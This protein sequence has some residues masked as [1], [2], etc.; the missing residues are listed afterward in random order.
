M[1]SWHI[2]AK[3]LELR[4]TWKISR[5][6]S[7]TK[8][9]L[10]VRVTDQ[11]HLGRGEAAPNVR[12][13]ETPELLLTQFQNLLANGLEYVSSLPELQT[14]LEQRSIA[15]ALRFAVESA[16]VHFTCMVQQV[17][18]SQ[19]LGLSATQ[20][21]PTIFSLPIMAP[22]LVGGF[23]K[24]N[25]LNRFKYLKIK[26]NQA[27]AKALVRAVAAVTEQP[28]IIDGNE[29]WS[30]P[31]E[32]IPLLLE[33]KDLPIQFIEQ[34]MPAHEHDAYRYLKKNTPFDIFA[35]E[36][37]TDQP[38]FSQL[39]PEFHGVNMKLMKAGGYLNGRRI[40]TET[41]AC[42]LKTMVGCMV[43]TSLGIWSAMQLCD[44]V[45]YA[46]LDGFLILKEDPFGMVKEQ[47][48]LITFAK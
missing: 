22:A 24:E 20:A 23:I 37:V 10:F 8:T 43:E 7:D 13:Q 5:N 4:Y 30:N 45:T 1:L 34:P 42:G 40:L 48:G 28:L 21:V 16:Y 36:S 11:Q 3:Q 29:A 39:Q 17:P 19:Y 2:E 44:G 33:L 46:D 25:K 47:H 27:D 26:V 35:D 9:N 6:A 32:L 12:Y 18:V 15:N 14:L 41:R 38:D 31:D